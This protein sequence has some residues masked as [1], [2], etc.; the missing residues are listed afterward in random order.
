MRDSWST[1]CTWF[2]AVRQGC[3]QSAAWHP[4]YSLTFANSMSNT[5]LNKAPERRPKGVFFSFWFLLG[6]L[7]N[8]NIACF[9]YFV[10]YIL[11]KFCDSVTKVLWNFFKVSTLRLILCSDVFQNQ[12]LEQYFFGLKRQYYKMRKLPFCK[13][14]ICYQIVYFLKLHS[15]LTL[16]LSWISLYIKRR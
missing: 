9:V 6:K 10:L 16:L 14:Q 8:L 12:L 1:A 5:V 7:A 3:G 13:T 15:K 2:P 11:A 4:M